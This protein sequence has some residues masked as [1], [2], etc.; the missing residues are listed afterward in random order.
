MTF[1]NKKLNFRPQNP[2]EE[3]LLNMKCMCL[4][5]SKQFLKILKLY[6]I[7]EPCKTVSVLNAFYVPL[8]FKLMWR[9]LVFRQ[10]YFY[11]SADET[12]ICISMHTHPYVKKT[13]F[14]RAPNYSCLMGSM[15]TVEFTQ[16]GN[17]ATTAF[18][19]TNI[20]CKCLILYS[21]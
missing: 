11:I 9:A 20:L 8:Y 2:K 4:K 5:F 6:P 14:Y 7:V 13:G 10:E 1:F 18:R 19:P 15:G 17:L 21:A 12:K 3:I 16:N